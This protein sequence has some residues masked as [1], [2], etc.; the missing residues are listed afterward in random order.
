MAI[1]RAKLREGTSVTL[2]AREFS[3]LGDE[4]V[5]AGGTDMGPDPYEM[6]LGGLASCIAATLRL[7]ADHKG[8]ELVGVDVELEFDRVHVEDTGNTDHPSDGRIERIQSRVKLH[9]TFDEAQ[10]TRLAQVARRC[11]VHKTL[12]NGVAFEDSVEFA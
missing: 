12:A 6:L 5:G 3:W 11:P 8:I 10:R 2:E 9:G 1:V 7:Y 4:P